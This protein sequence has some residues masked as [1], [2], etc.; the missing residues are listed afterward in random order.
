[1]SFT[2]N[3]LPEPAALILEGDA[4][5]YPILQ[6]EA[7][8]TGIFSPVRRAIE[9][10]RPHV[11]DWANGHLLAFEP[12]GSFAK[13]TSNRTGTDIDLFISVAETASETLQQV[14]EKLFNCMTDAGFGP[15]RKA[16][17]LNVTVDGFDVD[18]VPGK[19]Q[20]IFTTDHSL[21]R[22]KTGTWRQTNVGTHIRL[23][24]GSPWRPVIRALKLWRCQWAFEMPS[25]LIELMVLEA[26]NGKR[27][28]LSEGVAIAL[29]YVAENI[30][31]RRVVDPAN[32]NNVLTDELTKAE[33]RLIRNYAEI[34]LGS[35]WYRFIQ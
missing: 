31:T 1:M 26:L 34:A 9:I 5:L 32:Q 23:I 16:V 24:A 10:L 35:S 8:N 27:V 18:L 13:G 28:H 11:E 12:S 7:V 17:S 19:R 14:Y 4:H 29:R 2:R 22:T 15:K 6:R 21:Y 30:E 33:K 25:F 3:Y 20:S